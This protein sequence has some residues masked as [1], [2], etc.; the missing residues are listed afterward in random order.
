MYGISYAPRTGAQSYAGVSGLNLSGSTDRFGVIGTSSG[1][2]SGSVYS[3]GVGGYGD[4]GVL[5]NSQSTTGAGVLA[6]HSSGKTA[7]E[8]NNGFIKVS[9]TNKT[10][11]KHTTAAGNIAGDYTIL[12]YD[13]PSA[14]DI[15]I[16]THNNSPNNTY[17]NKSIGV[18]WTGAAWAIYLEDQT[19]MTANLT[20]NVMV[21]KQ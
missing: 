17:L 13:S 6:Q 19:T 10:A 12:T 3:A 18:F 9:G 14:N 20:F 15:L 2:T 16:V 8:V 1:T 5:G 4:Y 11:F 21:I 7:L